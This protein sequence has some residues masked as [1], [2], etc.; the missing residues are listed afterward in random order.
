ALPS[1]HLPVRDRFPTV[2]RGDA[3]RSAKALQNAHAVSCGDAPG[4]YASRAVQTE[5]LPS[6]CI[7]VLTWTCQQVKRE[8]GAMGEQAGLWVR[9]SSGGQDEANQ[10]P[11]VEKHAAARGYEVARRYV[12]HDKSASK[13]EQQAMLDQAVADMAAG[14]IS[15]LAVWHSDRLDRRGP[16]AAY[17]FL[18]AAELAGGRIESVLDPQFGADDVGAE[19]LARV[20]MAAARDESR[21]KAERVR[22]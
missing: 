11:D 1:L 12:L 13:G 22:I 3:S 9:V 10:V 20:R 15:V 5:V 8:D 18:W 7:R 21:L 2:P 16:K 14:V 6:G 17:A 4:H 19:V